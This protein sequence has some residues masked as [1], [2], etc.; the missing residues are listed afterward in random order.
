[1]LGLGIES[2][3][4]VIVVMNFTCLDYCVITSYWWLFFLY[5]RLQKERAM[6]KLGNCCVR[7]EVTS[8]V[9]LSCCSSQSVAV[10]QESSGS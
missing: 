2:A 5:D 7:D 9:G 3:Y 8:M 1:M 10:V 4:L 6:N